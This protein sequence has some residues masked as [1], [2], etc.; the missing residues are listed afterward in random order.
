MSYTYRVILE[1]D[2]G[3]FHAYV[4]ALLGCHTWGKNIDEAR[5]MVRDAIDV[6]LRSLIADGK[7]IP[8]DTGFESFETV[9]VP[10]GV[11]RSLALRWIIGAA[12]SGKGKPMHLKLADEIIAASKNEGSAIKKRDDIHRMAE[13]N[14][15]FAHLAW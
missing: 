12:R 2:E 14:R 7:D 4:P 13:S 15:A 11:K 8:H 6:Y 9:S 5:A 3:G 10:K 1:P